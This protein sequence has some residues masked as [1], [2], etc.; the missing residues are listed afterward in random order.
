MEFPELGKH[1]SLENCKQL[2]FLPVDCDLC[3]KVFCKDH[4]GYEQHACTEKYQKDRRVPVCPLC[5]QPVSIK[6]G[7]IPDRR[8]N[9]HIESDCK[10]DLA[11]A[12]RK[13]YTNKCSVKG[14]KQR[15]LV[16]VTCATCRKNFCLRHRHEND[17]ECID[18]TATSSKGVMK[19]SAAQAAG[20]AAAA[21]FESYN[22]SRRKQAPMRSTASATSNTSNSNK[23]LRNQSSSQGHSQTTIQ[24]HQGGMTEDEALAFALQASLADTHQPKEEE[25]SSNAVNSDEDSALARAIAQSEIDER[26]RQREA[27][28]NRT[29]KTH[30]S[31]T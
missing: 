15:E 22:T 23:Q 9:D 12:K 26:N 17:H 24:N 20:Q 18:L 2:D 14:C 19:S 29:E 13:T 6:P 16:P 30:C 21:R 1:C 31:V 10:S 5:N 25:H 11:L 7:E 3:K 4:V 27:S 8:V 28:Q